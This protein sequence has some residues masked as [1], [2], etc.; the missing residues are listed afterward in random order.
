MHIIP[1]ETIFCSSLPAKKKKKHLQYLC[2]EWLMLRVVLE[3][4][5]IYLMKC[6]AKCNI[7]DP[8]LRVA[9]L[10]WPLQH[11]F[12]VLME[13]KGYNGERER[14]K[15]FKWSPGLGRR[16]VSHSEWHL[17][18]SWWS[19]SEIWRGAMWTLWTPHRCQAWVIADLTGF[20]LHCVGAKCWPIVYSDLFV[21]I[22]SVCW[23]DRWILV[24]MLG[25]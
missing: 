21:H 5:Y 10:F 16:V 23:R 24:F 19:V 14:S 7:F 18:R 13:H 3:T 2:I 15:A 8:D 11:I 6:C 4:L 12:H 20:Y 1:T 25:Y 17:N 9:S 22:T